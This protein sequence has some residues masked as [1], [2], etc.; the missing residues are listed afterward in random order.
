MLPLMTGSEDQSYSRD[1]AIHHSSEGMFAIRKGDWKLIEG[2][3]SG[4]FSLPRFIDPA[5]GEPVGQ[6]YNLQD[7]PQETENL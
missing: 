4:G 5:P 7:D 1:H 6:L 2:R 3:G